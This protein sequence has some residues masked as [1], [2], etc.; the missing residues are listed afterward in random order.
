MWR[1]V[2]LVLVSAIGGCGGGDFQVPAQPDGR[3]NLDL[4]VANNFPPDDMTCFNAACGGCSSLANWDGTP[5]KVGDPCLWNGTW[6]CSGTQLACSSAAC[7]SCAKPVRGTACG[8]DGHTIVELLTNGATC[9][10]YDFGSAISTCNHQPADACVAE[11]SIE[12]DGSYTCVAH[13]ASDDGGGTGL[14]HT[15]G[16]TCAS[17]AT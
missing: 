4:A 7:L 9:T 13:C 3:M 6:Q 1:V 2:G 14:M 12:T 17:L 15:A 11:C 16:E 10:S 5:V 8:A